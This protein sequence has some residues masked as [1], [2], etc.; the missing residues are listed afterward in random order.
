M[1]K[2][3]ISIVLLIVGYLLLAPT[4]VDPI[5]WDSTP[6]KKFKSININNNFSIIEFKHGNGPEDVAIATNGNIYGGLK[7]GNIEK[8][9][10]DNNKVL[11]NTNG[12]P[13]GL[14]FDKDY[15]IIADSKKGL[16][17]MDKNGKIDVLVS[18]YNSKAFKYADDLDI[19]KDGTIYF[20]DASLK[21]SSDETLLCFLESGGDGR[22]FKYNVK[23]NQ[24]SLLLDNLFFANGI[25][26]SHDENYVL[27]VESTRYRVSRY[28]IRG[29]RIGQS[30]V[31]LDNING[32]PDGI[33]K[34]SDGGYWI[35]LVSK[36]SPIL[37]KF[38][39]NPL[40]RKIISRIPQWLMPKPKGS[41]RFL[42][43]SNKGKI[44]NYYELDN[45][46]TQN[47]SSVEEFGD[48]IYLG[49]FSEPRTVKITTSSI[50]KHEK[51]LP[52]DP[53]D[54]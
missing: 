47:I 24:T 9:N 49:S 25:A 35:A 48:S 38:S 15:L 52:I 12:R 13:L 29:E 19:S 20:S 21:Y 22:L 34:A 11:G 46:I 26:I 51:A 2:Y 27:V 53:K 41:A 44:Q 43:V 1:L 42:K 5:N 39:N 6:A 32:V 7:N 31:F 4:E 50:L 40:A 10:P 45:N 23:T 33:S 3:S 18:Q 16:L 30:D 28:W 14:H 36:R 17:S 54:L 8:I 37:D